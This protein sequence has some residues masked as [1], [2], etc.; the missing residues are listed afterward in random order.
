MERPPSTGNY[1]DTNRPESSGNYQDMDRPEST[2]LLAP[3]QLE[4]PDLQPGGPYS[5]VSNHNTYELDED[6]KSRVISHKAYGEKY[7]NKDEVDEGSRPKILRPGAV[8]SVPIPK[9][10]FEHSGPDMDAADL[11]RL[12]TS[13]LASLTGVSEKE[14]FKGIGAKLD[15]VN[16]YLG[17]ESPE[18]AEELRSG[19]N[20]LKKAVTYLAEGLASGDK[21]ATSSSL[22]GAKRSVA[23]MY[24][25]GN[26]TDDEF[27]ELNDMFYD[28][29]HVI[30][31]SAKRGLAEDIYNRVESLLKQGPA[32]N[33]EDYEEDEPGPEPETD[34][35]TTEP[36]Q[37]EDDS[38]AENPKEPSRTVRSRVGDAGRKA[39]IELP[40]AAEKVSRGVKHRLGA[41]AVGTII[42]FNAAK[43]ARKNR[44]RSTG[45]AK[46][47]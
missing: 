19:G 15:A 25:K 45:E 27:A 17:T 34:P 47:A 4:V 20:R 1:A 38:E 32:E 33:Y 12:P 36:G 23:E 16:A 42:N 8:G 40:G 35:A 6:G 26:L 10:T 13:E 30:S 18:P 39:Y 29:D 44:R 11:L 3:E 41:L 31:T 14:L 43:E 2:G 7:D 5:R 22:K 28:A 37:E 9:R 21:E 46:A 24:K